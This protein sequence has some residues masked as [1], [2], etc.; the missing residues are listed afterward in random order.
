[1]LVG[2]FIKINCLDTKNKYSHVF[3]PSL[4]KVS[5]FVLLHSCF[6]YKIASSPALSKV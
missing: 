3:N 2:N 1:M 6:R 4:G 5:I